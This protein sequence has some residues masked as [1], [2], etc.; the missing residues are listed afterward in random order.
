MHN[1]SI[2]RA[3][4]Q[5]LFAMP[6]GKNNNVRNWTSVYYLQT[7]IRHHD[8]VVERNLDWV[9]FILKV[10]YKLRIEDIFPVIPYD[11]SRHFF[12]VFLLTF[13][14]SVRLKCHW[15]EIFVSFFIRRIYSFK[16]AC[17]HGELYFCQ[18]LTESAGFS[19][20][21]RLYGAKRRPG[22]GTEVKDHARPL[23]SLS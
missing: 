2:S 12:S 17:N 4:C 16:R 6:C 18:H 23:I 21:N 9:E 14:K 10:N 15:N 11:T 1:T 5:L 19:C 20:R 8:K 3:N 7:I 22:A 13:S